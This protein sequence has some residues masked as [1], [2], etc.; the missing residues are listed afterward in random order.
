MADFGGATEF[1]TWDG[2]PVSRDRPYGATI[3]V[4]SHGP[5]GWRYVLLHRGQHG[6]DWDGDWA[7]TPPAGSR[8]P[9][10]DIAA[11]AARELQEET[12]LTAEPRPVVTADVD[13]ALFVLEVPW[14]TEVTLDG[15]EH[16]R[17]EWVS[18]AEASRRCRPDVLAASFRTGCEAAGFR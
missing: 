15:T 16:D 7:W 4:A 12:G 18:Y 8:K 2:E 5:D 3:V 17:L 9:S 1:T 11:C 13:W 14:G 6:A 10:E